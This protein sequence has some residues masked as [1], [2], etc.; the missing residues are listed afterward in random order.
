GKI[1][2]NSQVFVD[3]PVKYDIEQQKMIIKVCEND[4]SIKLIVL[5]P[6]RID[7]INIDGRI[8]LP[9][10]KNSLILPQKRYFER[11]WNKG[12]QFVIYHHISFDPKKNRRNITPGGFSAIYSDKIIIANKKIINVKSKRLF[13]KLFGSNKKKILEYMKSNNMRYRKANNSQLKQ[14]M[15]YCYENAS[16]N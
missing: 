15:Q 16:I 4:K 2:I 6:K 8:F 9:S 11:I 10:E 7:S 1:Y 14:L 12:F 5:N 13:L 3:I